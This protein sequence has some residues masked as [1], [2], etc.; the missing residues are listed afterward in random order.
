MHVL[1][2]LP[3]LHTTITSP[4]SGCAIGQS[5]TSMRQKLQKGK[6]DCMKYDNLISEMVLCKYNVFSCVLAAALA[7]EILSL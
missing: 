4:L 3:S 5:P 2:Y 1:C 7:F 6:N